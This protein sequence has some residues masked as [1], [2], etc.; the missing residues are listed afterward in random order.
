[1]INPLLSKWPEKMNG[2]QKQIKMQCSS[3][4]PDDRS[5]TQNSPFSFFKRMPISSS[6]VDCNHAVAYFIPFIAYSGPEDSLA[7]E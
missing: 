6:I 2:A 1:M 4:S 3:D 7:L 5:D